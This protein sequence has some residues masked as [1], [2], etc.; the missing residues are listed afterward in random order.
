MLFGTLEEKIMAR[1]PIDTK[2]YEDYCEL[3]QRYRDMNLPEMLKWAE[4]K[5]D[6]CQKEKRFRK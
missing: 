1:H 4:K 6:Q 3:V 5:R 2:T